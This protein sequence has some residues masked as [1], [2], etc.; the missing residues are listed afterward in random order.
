M[1]PADLPTDRRDRR[2]EDR[3][4]GVGGRRQSDPPLAP[5]P[6]LG[7]ARPTGPPDDADPAADVRAVVRVVRAAGRYPRAAA[8]VLSLCSAGAG[9]WSAQ[10]EWAQER[11]ERIAA[12]SA[13]VR[14]RARLE[15]RDSALTGALLDLNA[16]ICVVVRR[17]DPGAYEQ[18]CVAPPPPP[19]GLALHRTAA[20]STAVR[21]AP[22]VA[23]L[24]PAAD[25]RPRPLAR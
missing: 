20:Q 24:L 14:H 16:R 12:D 3:P 6:A 4:G 5:L 25:V 19:P 21:I 11:A 15:A 10:S 8:L 17:V 22:A 13:S 1:S 9:R 7:G 18:T 23:L 2:A